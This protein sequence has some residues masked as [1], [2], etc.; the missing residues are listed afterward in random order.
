MIYL[1]RNEYPFELPPKVTSILS[2]IPHELITHYTRVYQKN[3]KSVLSSYMS[4]FHG[5]PEQNVLLGYGSEDILKQAIHYFLEKREK[6]LV[7]E[8]SWWYYQKI[9]DEVGGITMQFPMRKTETKYY[10][11]V[12][13]IIK[14]YHSNY[15]KVIL[16]STPNNPTG[17][18]ISVEEL[19]VLVRE[20]PYSYVILD[21][22]YWGY[23]LTDDTH[24]KRF[25]EKYPNVLILRT[26]SK[27]YGLPGLRVGF[28]FIN[29][30]HSQFIDFSNRYLGFNRISEELAMAA[31]DSKDHYEKIKATVMKERDLFYKELRPVKGIRVFDT[32]TNFILIEIPEYAKAPL[33]ATLEENKILVKFMAEKGLENHVRVCFGKPETGVI[34]RKAFIEAVKQ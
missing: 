25:T 31:L 16:I 23:D 15:P 19:E 22:A 28:G 8:N 17:N 24:I 13:D 21:E 5:V 10:I 33:K 9:A 7:P 14:I 26:M 12:E 3:I 2:D 1:D 27:F 32:M 34:M 29:S 6:L 18:G 4:D 20:C 30:S 11:D